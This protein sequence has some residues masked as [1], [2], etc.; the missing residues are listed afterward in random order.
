M[1]SLFIIENPITA[2]VH[3]IVEKHKPNNSLL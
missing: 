1:K 3:D 2:N